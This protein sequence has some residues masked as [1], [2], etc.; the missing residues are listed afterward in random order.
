MLPSAAK[1]LFGLCDRAGAGDRRADAAAL[2][3]E[4]DARVRI[5]LDLPP[6]GG[7]G[8]RQLAGDG[9]GRAVGEHDPVEHDFDHARLLPRR[10]TRD[11][12]LPADPAPAGMIVYSSTPT[13][14]ST[15][16]SKV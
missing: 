9:D 16:V 3:D 7:V 4:H 15:V 2:T 8:A 1:M 11:G 14:W 13:L 5:A 12:D 10:G 6:L